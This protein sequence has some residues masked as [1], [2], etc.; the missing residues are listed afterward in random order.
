RHR[1]P[2]PSATGPEHAQSGPCT[3]DQD[4]ERQ[5]PVDALLDPAK[6]R[7]P[8]LEAFAIRTGID[9]RADIGRLDQPV[10]RIGR[11]AHYVRRLASKHRYPMP[12]RPRGQALSHRAGYWEG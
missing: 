4:A 6:T 12:D 11:R 1:E 9:P 5:H 10:E 7:I 3:H 2:S 8:L